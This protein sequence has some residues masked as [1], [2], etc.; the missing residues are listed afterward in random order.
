MPRATPWVVG[1]GVLV[2]GLVLTAPARS[3]DTKLKVKVGDP[4]PDI[5]LPATQAELVKKGGKELSIKDLKGKIVVVAF[6]PKAL[7]GG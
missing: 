3:D 1:A 6:Y 4:F 2:V 7:T 5:P